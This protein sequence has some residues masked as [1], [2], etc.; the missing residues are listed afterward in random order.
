[1]AKNE[2]LLKLIGKDVRY[3]YSVPIPLN[4]M[5]LIPGLETAPMNITAQNT[6]NKF[7]RVISKD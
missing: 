6:I 2:L 7:G 4:S 3:G 5:K 1:L